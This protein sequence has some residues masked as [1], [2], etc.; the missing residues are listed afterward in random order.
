MA[1][2][3]EQERQRLSELYARMSEGELR[4]IA[5]DA[6]SLT[7]IARQVLLEEIEKR[8]LDTPLPESGAVRRFEARDMVTVLQFRDLPEAL[9]AKGMLDSA[10]IECFLFDENMIRMDWFISN[11]LGGIRLRVNRDD[12]EEAVMLLS[13]PIPQGF[14]IEG[15]G[16]YE[17]PQCPHCGSFDIAHHA[18]LDKRFALPAL[19]VAGIPIPVVRNEWK[20]QSCGAKWLDSESEKAEPDL[21]SD[22]Q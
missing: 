12:V 17:Q 16:K 9:L 19:C 20:C 2:S 4:E 6:V 21:S 14:D 13:D 3:S 18:G 10:G 11:L 8:G 1:D 7:D 5:N 22:T 15:L